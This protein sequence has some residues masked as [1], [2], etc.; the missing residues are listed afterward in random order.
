MP[1]EVESIRFN[2]TSRDQGWASDPQEGSWSWFAVSIL[3]PLTEDVGRPIHFEETEYIK[4]QPEDFGAQLQDAGYYFEDIITGGGDGEDQTASI[5]M[6]LVDNQIEPRWQHHSITW[7]RLGGNDGSQLIS[8]LREGDRLVIWACAEFPGWVNCVK[9]A[10]IFVSSASPM[11]PQT[12]EE[13]RQRSPVRNALPLQPLLKY[14]TILDTRP[15]F[16]EGTRDKASAMAT[17]TSNTKDSPDY[18]FASYL[19][20]GD[21]DDLDKRLREI[22][23]LLISTP[24]DHPARCSLLYLT[25]LGFAHR[26]KETKNNEDLDK[27]VT[28][29]QLVCLRD[30]SIY[31]SQFLF[32]R[33]L[34]ERYKQYHHEDDL[35]KCINFVERI[36]AGIP[37]GNGRI[38]ESLALKIQALI[39]RHELKRKTEDFDQISAILDKLFQA[40]D[41]DS[42]IGDLPSYLWAYFGSQEGYSN[43]ENENRTQDEKW[44]GIAERLLVST[45]EN[46]KRRK[47]L[48]FRSA[49][50]LRRRYGRTGDMEDLEKSILRMK[51]AVSSFS[52]QPDTCPPW[53]LSYFADS[54]LE[55][56]KRTGEVADLDEAEENIKTA[57]ML[58]QDDVDTSWRIY[59]FH[60]LG[61]LSIARFD[62]TQSI[63]E[64]EAAI[65]MIDNL[66]RSSFE[67][68]DVFSQTLFFSCSGDLHQ[69]MYHETGRVKHLE[70]AIEKTNC[71]L[72]FVPKNDPM[73]NSILRKRGSLLYQ[74][75]R[76]KMDMQHGVNSFDAMWESVQSPDQSPLQRIVTAVSAICILWTYDRDC[77]KDAA[78]IISYILPLIPYSCGRDLKRQD[79][80]HT[81]KWV[82]Q[83][84]G[85]AIF[86]F[87]RNDNIESALRSLELTRGLVINSLLDDQSDISNLQ[88]AHPELAKTYNTLRLHALQSGGLDDTAVDDQGQNERRAAYKQLQ[89]CEDKIRQEPGFESFQQQVSLE[90]L[91]Q[92]AEEGPIVIV[93]TI[94]WGSDAILVTQ[95]GTY[96]IPLLEMSE[97]APLE[98]QERLSRSV[99]IDFTA[100]RDL[101]SDEQPVHQS[102]ELLSWLWTTC[103]EPILQV[104]TSKG[105]IS[106]SDKKSRVWWIGTGSASILPFHAAGDYIDGILVPGRSCLDKVISSYTP[107]IKV[108]ANA[109]ARAAQRACIQESNN[110]KDSLLLVTMPT[111]PGSSDLLGA[112]RESEAIAKTTGQS[113]IVEE[114]EQ[115]NAGEVLGRLRD[116]SGI[117][118]FACHG[119]SDPNDPSLSHLLLQKQ[120]EQGLVADKLSV[121]NL[122]DTRFEGQAW[123]AYLSA[124]STANIKDQALAD[125]SLHIT[126]G[127][128]ISGFAHVIGSLWSADDDVCVRMATHFYS[129]LLTNR[130]SKDINRAVARAV[131]DAQ[132][133]IRHEYAHDP[134]MWA[135][136]V[137]VGA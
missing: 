51:E 39:E 125:E 85:M 18:I 30:L 65:E 97:R 123:I 5:S 17:K 100:S 25:G 28:Y 8:L 23:E 77:W 56:F 26:H 102:I 68:V 35:D 74:K 10:S 1:S 21:L 101:E 47:E 112:R 19:K 103:V 62:C 136:Y 92:I 120:T 37:S 33:M 59:A 107:T 116:H 58:F 118:H 52:L 122:L 78:R 6:L 3:R 98:F 14:P 128:L 90:T 89:S 42:L 137:H 132:L 130:V 106:T 94:G 34:L 104:L 60:V 67:K 105:A 117:V 87:L 29:S 54:L 22:E 110:S 126:S 4:S 95:S 119:Y 73:R 84:A 108:L 55:R 83:T 75:H 49:I 15:T 44:I 88:R 53:L 48:L 80:I 12:C 71:A 63:T 57:V 129:S 41:R 66:D 113:L 121:T 133:Q 61:Q 134:S 82:S 76:A 69:T 109:R 111:T 93:N 86:V 24:I 91:S 50:Y 45:S 9:E 27:A 114:M 13:D 131:H 81:A 2:I 38:L 20:S 124:C 43:N 96:T 31:E 32:A 36:M 99:D 115:P 64:L 135:L 127:F 79:Q 46:D 72:T 16:D 40:R 7:T 11:E 70:I